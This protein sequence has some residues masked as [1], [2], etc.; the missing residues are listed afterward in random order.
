MDA[1]VTS[2]MVFGPL[3]IAIL[4]RAHSAYHWDKNH[5]TKTSNS[6][7]PHPICTLC[8]FKQS[9][10]MSITLPLHSSSP[11]FCLEHHKCLH[12]SVGHGS[13]GGGTSSVVIYC[14]RVIAGVSFKLYWKLEEWQKFEKKKRWPV[15]VEITV[16]DEHDQRVQ[17][18]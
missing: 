14:M 12:T 7:Y 4:M 9:P 1:G 6:L 3:C 10:I 2:A 11:T 5:G 8:G 16:L 17:T 13:G 18:R 15:T